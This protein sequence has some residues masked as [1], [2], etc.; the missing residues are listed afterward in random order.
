MKINVIM[1]KMGESIN[2]G[3]IIKWHKKEGDRVKK[4]EIIFEISTDKVD[5]EIPSPAEG[6]LEKILVAEQQTVEVDTVVATIE[7]SDDKSAGEKSSSETFREQ[8]GI[9]SQKPSAEV[10]PSVEVSETVSEGSGNTIQAETAENI[11]A[12]QKPDASQKPETRSESSFFSPLVMSI[13]EK[14]NVTLNELKNLKGTGNGGRITKNDILKYIESRNEK[15]ETGIADKEISEPVYSDIENAYNE[16]IPEPEEPKENRQAFGKE[17]KSE[18]AAVSAS[19]SN[20][21]DPMR[22]RIMNHMISSRDTSVHV[23]GVVEADV[24]GISDFIKNNKDLYL[25]RE[26]LK[27]TY[28]P[29]VAYACIRALKEH[30]AV[31]SSID[32]TNI[33]LKKNIN[34]GFAVALE[35]DGLIVPNIKNADMKNLKGIAYEIS[36][37]S[38]KAR[39]RKLTPDDITGGTFTITNYGPFGTLFGTP[40]INQ[41]EVA[42]L[43][44]G[45]VTKKAVVMEIGGI[46]TIAVRSM[47]YLSLSHDHRIIDGM[48]GGRF[49]AMIKST[50][51]TTDWA[52]VF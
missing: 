20:P 7:T 33:V 47:M 27:L 5:T 23:A 29:F 34:L 2:E 41:P 43:G 42:I 12:S 45:A 8:E 10:K 15:K 17:S 13:A 9:T 37:L 51:E 30:P 46:E 24:T 4:D 52:G 28:M 22:I 49:L 1:P 35:P 11:T 44:T 38:K 39:S 6:I 16:V 32:G 40:V 48:L 19:E 25:K 50:L 21:M 18:P 36:S 14:E 31:N 3:T 26:N